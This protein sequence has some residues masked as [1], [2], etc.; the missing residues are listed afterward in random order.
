MMQQG[1][2]QWKHTVKNPRHAWQWSVWCRLQSTRRG[3]FQL[4]RV[5]ICSLLQYFLS[6]K[7]DPR[8]RDAETNLS[9]KYNGHTGDRATQR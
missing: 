9:P 3:N 1:I 2:L 4:L 8:G 7:R 5:E 6:S